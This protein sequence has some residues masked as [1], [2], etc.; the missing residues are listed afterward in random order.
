MIKIVDFPER[1]RVAEE[2]AEWLIRLDSDGGL[3]PD[4][5]DALKAWVAKS[6]KHRLAL[7]RLADVWGGMNVLTELSV[8]LGKLT[9]RRGGTDSNSQPG[10]VRRFFGGWWRVGLVAATTIIVSLVIL[11]RIYLVES[12]TDSNG[13]YATVIGQQE[14]E[15]LIDGSAILLNTNT[16]IRVSY[17][18]DHRDVYLLQGE[19]LFTVAKDVTR[20][21]RVYAGSGRIQAVGTAFS[22]YLN[23]DNV[24]VTVTEGEVALAS[25]NVS[26]PMDPVFGDDALQGP[27]VAGSKPSMAGDVIEVLDS[28]Q[29]GQV[30]TI[31]GSPA[32]AVAIASANIEVKGQIGS[33]ELEQRL[34]WRDG[35]LMFSG[36]SLQDVVNQISRYTTV[37][38]EIPEE[39]VRNMRIGGRFPVG[40]TETMLTALETNF[41]LRVTR[42]GHDRVILS[43]SAKQF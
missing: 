11:F 3:T 35:I 28:L 30:A 9:M 16:Q 14:S 41:D 31:R 6:P 2:A 18:D 37:S 21:F 27:S 33:D 24:D 39:S 36:D 19:A 43:A 7:A 23:G 34:A 4:E 22:V 32:D 8:P 13:L 25:I 1:E 15:M 29:A 42:V 10:E 17:S 5:T 26:Q 38:I 40:E 12:I 20:P